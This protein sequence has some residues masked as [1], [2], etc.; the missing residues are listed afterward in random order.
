MV[1]APTGSGKTVVF[2]LAIIR[3]LNKLNNFTQTK[4]KVIYSKLNNFNEILDICVLGYAD[5]E[6]QAS[7]LGKSF[8]CTYNVINKSVHLQ[9][10]SSLIQKLHITLFFFIYYY[11]FVYFI[12]AI[13]PVHNNLI[14][15][16]E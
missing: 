10:F 9:C 5:D 1:S 15:V 2:E 6:S 7:Y 11:F 8:I 12:V 4:F 16:R 13:I 3:L 14:D